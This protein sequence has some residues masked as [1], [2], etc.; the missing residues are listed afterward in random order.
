MRN[1]AGVKFDCI[2]EETLDYID[3]D[4]TH[5]NKTVRYE[6]QP[7]GEWIPC[8]ERLTEKYRA[9]IVTD[10]TGAV[11]EYDYNNL[12]IHDGKWS[13]CM[14]EIVAWMPLPEPYEKGETR[15]CQTREKSN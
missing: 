2:F 1:K 3:I 9:Y 12:T 11:F 14:R 8:S 13:Y 4:Y 7:H 5:L 10:E 6:K 15:E